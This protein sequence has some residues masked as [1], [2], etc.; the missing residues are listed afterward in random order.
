MRRCSEYQSEHEQIIP[1]VWKWDGDG[2]PYYTTMDGCL[3]PGGCFWIPG[4]TLSTAD[5]GQSNQYTGWNDVRPTSLYF[6][7]YEKPL[8]SSCKEQAYKIAPSMRYTEH[9][10]NAAA[11]GMS[12][13]KV[14][15]IKMTTIAW[16]K[17]L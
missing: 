16:S 3:Q 1:G 2:C 15:R 7:F 13:A 4:E 11:I 10:A 8:S 17:Y 14:K 6:E 5:F 9:V 12:L